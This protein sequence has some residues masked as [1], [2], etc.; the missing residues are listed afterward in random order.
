M[1]EDAAI[2]TAK[3]RPGMPSPVLSTRTIDAV[4]CGTA[5]RITTLSSLLAQPQ[6]RGVSRNRHSFLESTVLVRWSGG[7]RRPI[8]GGSDRGTR[9]E[10]VTGESVRP[11]HEN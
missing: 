1:H 10:G 3:R 11:G 6:E 8:G 9:L 5:S 4:L 2:G 7:D